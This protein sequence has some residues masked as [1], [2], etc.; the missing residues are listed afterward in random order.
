MP[1]SLHWEASGIADANPTE[2][3][4]ASGSKTAFKPGKQKY[5]S[6]GQPWMGKAMRGAGRSHLPSG[7]QGPEPQSLWKSVFLKLLT[8]GL[9]MA[10]VR[11]ERGTAAGLR[12]WDAN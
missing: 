9:Q 10:S 6:S 2:T 1:S 8:P 12:G 4:C 3:G 7:L 5:V 11:G